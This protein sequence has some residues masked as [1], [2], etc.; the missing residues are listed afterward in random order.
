MMGSSLYDILM[1]EFQEVGLQA[2]YDGKSTISIDYD[3]KS[4]SYLEKLLLDFHDKDGYNIRFLKSSNR[5][6]F[7]LGVGDQ[8]IPSSSF[9]DHVLDSL[10][11][12][13]EEKD[14]TKSFDIECEKLYHLF[15]ESFQ[16]EGNFGIGLQNHGEGIRKC[17]IKTDMK[18]FLEIL[19]V[20]DIPVR[21]H[22][23]MIEQSEEKSIASVLESIHQEVLK[24]STLQEETRQDV[25]ETDDNVIKMDPT[26]DI[27][28]KI[29]Q[30][31]GGEPVVVRL[32][33][34]KQTKEDDEVYERLVNVSYIDQD[35]GIS[36]S[37][38]VFGY[39]DGYA[40]DHD[41]LPH[42]IDGFSRDAELAGRKVTLKE[43]QPG[44][45]YIQS[46]DGEDSISL[47][48][49]P[50][51]NVRSL[52]T[53]EQ[54]NHLFGDEEGKIDLQQLHEDNVI[55]PTDKGLTFEEDVADESMSEDVPKE[56][57]LENDGP[58]MVKKIGEMP[59]NSGVANWMGIALFLTIDVVAIAIG[60]YL[61]LQ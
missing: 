34:T 25:V 21:D 18:E 15:K 4:R 13:E 31:K 47:D 38:Q 40:F 7:T 26:V 27:Y 8:N 29:I 48:D 42:I 33:I 16:Y 41:V 44:S 45:C 14:Y 17:V 11:S 32:S 3:E 37:N 12:Y 53:Y 2:Q 51:D 58:K 6:S 46:G 55:S 10:E 60:I 59:S 24:R 30:D 61:L 36:T 50:V 19:Q 20:L 39:E 9:F 43:N 52:L 57:G 56:E 35:S 22:R 49:Y 1:R 23:V 54:E 28:E 5:A